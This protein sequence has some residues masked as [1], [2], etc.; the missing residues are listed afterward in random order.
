MG[1]KIL[2][3]KQEADEIFSA[4]MKQISLP[5]EDHEPSKSR[6][7]RKIPNPV[8]YQ[9]QTALNKLDG[10]DRSQPAIPGWKGRHLLEDTVD[11]LDE[12][13]LCS[14]QYQSPI[15]ADLHQQTER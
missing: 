8:D 13:L 7:M 15:G 6:C 9:V 1:N 14:R 12:H 5:D 3:R 10:I 2:I 4:A 11:Q